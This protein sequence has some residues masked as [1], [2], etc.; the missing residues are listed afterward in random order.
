MTVHGAAHHPPY[1]ELHRFGLRLFIASEAF[2]FGVLFA[3][4]FYLLGFERA[5]AVNVTLGVVLTIILLTATWSSHRAAAAARAGDRGAM[6]GQLLL[7]MALGVLFLALVVVEWSAGFREFPI[8]TPYGSIFYL[9]T[10]THSLHLLIGLFVLA[11]LFLQ[12]RR[13]RLGEGDV[14]KVEGGVAYWQFVDVVWL[15]VF[16]ILYVL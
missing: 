7:T 2:L 12:A 9:I 4:R 6:Q 14:W 15:F 1:A 16:T 5:E 10:G 3:A 11:S 13:G 8:S